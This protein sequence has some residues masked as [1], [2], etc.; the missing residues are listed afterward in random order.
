MFRRLRPFGA[1]FVAADEPLPL[2]D[3]AATF[4][5]DVEAPAEADA[6]PA[7]VAADLAL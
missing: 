4:E 5:P 7:V 1:L 3:A 2:P 6:F